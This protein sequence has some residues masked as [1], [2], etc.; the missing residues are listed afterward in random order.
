MLDVGC[1]AGGLGAALS[2]RQA[3]A[4]YTG[5]DISDQA[6]AAAR[7]RVPLSVPA[8]FIAGD[9]LDLSDLG[10]TAFDT[11]VSL[12]CADWN[13]ETGR[14][15][16][17]CWSLVAPRG[18]FVPS[19]GNPSPTARTPVGRV[20][21]AVFAATK[22]REGE[23]EASPHLDLRLLRNVWGPRLSAM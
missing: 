18:R 13:V 19:L 21:F 10:R 6:I 8:R 12:S 2:E 1:A 16:E 17:R 20:V 9:I 15:L 3:L 23:S 4:S 11:V 14:I 22:A 7:V 5:V